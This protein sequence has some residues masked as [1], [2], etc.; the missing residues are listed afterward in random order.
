M[1]PHRRSN[2]QGGGSARNG[3]ANGVGKAGLRG[4][5]GGLTFDATAAGALR[6]AHTDPRAT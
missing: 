4:G 5:Q 1:D 2:R 6:R 3:G